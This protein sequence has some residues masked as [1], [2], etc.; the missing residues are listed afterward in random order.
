[1]SA[2]RF[3]AWRRCKVSPRSIGKN[4]VDRCMNRGAYLSREESRSN[5]MRARKSARENVSPFNSHSVAHLFI[6]SRYYRPPPVP[7]S[8]RFSSTNLETMRLIKMKTRK[9]K[10]HALARN[11]RAFEPNSQRREDNIAP[12]TCVSCPTG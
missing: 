6:A 2:A 9:K 3:Y 7:L 12:F 4:P 8:L 11:A 10:G 1:M 5:V